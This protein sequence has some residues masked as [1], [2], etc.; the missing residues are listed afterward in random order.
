MMEETPKTSPK[1]I[2]NASLDRRKLVKRWMEIYGCPAPRHSQSK[3]LIAALD[4]HHQMRIRTEESSG[5]VDSMIRGLRKRTATQKPKATAPPG[6]RLLRE[7]QG[8]THHI[9]VVNDGF[10]YEGK[11]YKSL[12][13]IARLITGTAWSG[14]LFFGLRS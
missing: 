6:T 2:S 3:L 1:F 7:W 10:E 9:T 13:A 8:K 5:N 12:T 11:I 4:W 14:P